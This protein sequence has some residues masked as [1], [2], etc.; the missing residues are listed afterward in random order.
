MEDWFI[1]ISYIESS[2]SSSYYQPS[3]LTY[4]QCQSNKILTFS[5]INYLVMEYNNSSFTLLAGVLN[6]LDDFIARLPGESSFRP[7]GEQLHSYKCNETEYEIYTVSCC[8]ISSN[9]SD[10]F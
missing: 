2:L 8:S 6:N 1:V 7:M 4:S 5:I 3:T 10:S 9:I